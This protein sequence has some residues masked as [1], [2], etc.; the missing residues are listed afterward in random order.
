MDQRHTTGA[1]KAL[2][3]ALVVLA[4]ALVS[5][6]LA[7]PAKSKA[8]RSAKSPAAASAPAKRAV[9]LTPDQL[10]AIHPL[11]EQYED[12]LVSCRVQIKAY[13]ATADSVNPKTT[14]DALR[15][16]AARNA[17][18]ATS[19]DKEWSLQGLRPQKITYRRNLADPA[20]Q[21]EDK[22]TALWR[23]LNLRR[24]E[25]LSGV[26]LHTISDISGVEPPP[27]RCEAALTMYDVKGRYDEIMGRVPAS[28]WRQHLVIRLIEDEMNLRRP[29]LADSG[30]QRVFDQLVRMREDVL[31]QCRAAGQLKACLAPRPQ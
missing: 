15:L 3:L 21:R 28:A 27:A 22:R 23:C 31:Q 19:S 24:V 9:V 26:P 8:A 12:M 10:T 7:A 1:L 14:R 30:E 2:S 29:C 6:S 11:T 5:S 18:S 16:D 13:V 17:R 20:E 4:S 25:Q